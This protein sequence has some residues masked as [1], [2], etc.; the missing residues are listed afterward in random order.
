MAF[1]LSGTYLLLLE[2]PEKTMEKL[3]CSNY[4]TTREWYTWYFLKQDLPKR[5]H[6]AKHRRIEDII[7]EVA[8]EGWQVSQ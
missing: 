6:Y 4:N 7:I 8:E 1:V 3:R 5:M 2:P